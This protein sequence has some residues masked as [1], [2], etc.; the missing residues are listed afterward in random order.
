MNF[1]DFATSHGLIINSI[2]SGRWVRIPT[3]SHPRSKNGAY[4]FDGEY[5]FVQDWASMPSPVL[6][7][8]DRVLD[9]IELSAMQ[10]RMRESQKMYADARKFDQ[11]KAADKAR[12]IISQSKMETHAY[13]DYKGFPSALGLV[14]RPDEDTNLLAVPMRIGKEVVGVQLIDRD[15][16]KKFLTG[17]KTNDAEF[18]IGS[19]GQNIYCEGYATGLSIYTALNA[20]KIPARVH[21]CFSAGNLVRLAKNGIV[22]ADNDASGTGKKAAEST[23]LPYLMSEHIGEDFND[24]WRRIGTLRAGMLLRKKLLNFACKD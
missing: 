14:W 2:I 24:M 6:W 22:I 19:S 13:L 12:W 11:A 10:S 8:T 20:I 1:I 18:V 17:Q 4:F 16:G 15:G 21:V 3:R 9:A 7:K 23:N 5:G